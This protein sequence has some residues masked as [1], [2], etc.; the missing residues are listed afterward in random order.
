MALVIISKLWLS[1]LIGAGPR[2]NQEARS[3]VKVTP[4]VKQEDEQKPPNG[5]KS[6]WAS[7]SSSFIQAV[8]RV[9]LP[10]SS[11]AGH[12]P[13]PSPRQRHGNQTPPSSPTQQHS[14]ETP[15]P[16]SSW[17]QHSNQSPRQQHSNQIPSS[18]PRQQH[19]NQMPSSSPRQHHSNQTPSPI[20]QHSN[21]TARRVPDVL[22]TQRRS[23][24]RVVKALCHHLATEDGQLSLTKGDILT[25][26]QKVD[27]DWLLCC[28][29]DK[30][31]LVLT[32]CVNDLDLL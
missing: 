15:P 11:R 25:V 18:S 20:Q 24:K 23:D 12:T 1:N 9:L 16:P 14:N 4:E 6:R 17:Q 19:S 29:G 31:G 13:P 21:Q 7:F 8:D 32:G 5:R 22:Q 30:T 27:D 10:T 28:H 2:P 3:K 26:V